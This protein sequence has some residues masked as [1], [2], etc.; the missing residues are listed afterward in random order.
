[1]FTTSN[2]YPIVRLT[3]LDSTTTDDAWI[4]KEQAPGPDKITT[5]AFLI[6][7]RE[8]YVVIAHSYGSAQ[9]AGFMTIPKC[10]ITERIDYDEEE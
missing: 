4:Y 2:E 7:D 1:M 6:E 9:I 3:W 10:S 5:V 8:D